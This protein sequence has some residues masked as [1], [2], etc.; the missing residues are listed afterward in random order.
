MNTIRIL[1]PCLLG[2][3]LGGCASLGPIG[4]IAETL[5]TDLTFACQQ[6]EAP[7]IRTSSAFGPDYGGAAYGMPVA[8]PG[9]LAE[10]KVAKALVGAYAAASAPPSIPAARSG[11]LLSYTAPAMGE[12]VELTSEDLENFVDTFGTVS[13]VGVNYVKADAPQGRSAELTTAALFREYYLKYIK[14]DFVTRFGVKL[15]KPEIS[16]TIGSAT[17]S[18]VLSVF[19]EAIADLSLQT[20]VLEGKKDGKSIYY[21]GMSGTKPTAIAFD[22]PV[23]PIEALIE[24]STLCGL[25]V[26]EA[27]AVAWLANLAEDKSAIVSGMALESLGG[28][29]LSVVI[30]GHFSIGDNETLST[31]TKTFIA[32]SSKYLAERT[33]YEFFW[34]F[35]YDTLPA[36][37]SD[38]PGSALY[39]NSEKLVFHSAAP[40]GRSAGPQLVRLDSVASFLE[41]FG[42][43]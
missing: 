33:A 43:E 23:V 25:T 6:A 2:A 3:A 17:L 21:P 26:K 28:V 5:P 38:D 40:A 14:G 30:G 10:D 36:T 24:D 18:G 20:P 4:D 32:T 19:L 11:G 22:T 13:L 41:G 12:P 39:R 27:E 7:A 8:L 15:A 42:R 37:R 29:E 35:A 9:K 31:L 1:L 16:E 34:H